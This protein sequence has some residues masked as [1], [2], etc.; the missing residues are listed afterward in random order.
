[1]NYHYSK[2][3][4][5]LWPDGEYTKAIK[6]SSRSIWATKCIS[7]ALLQQGMYY[8]TYEISL[9]PDVLFDS[10]TNSILPL[11]KDLINTYGT[12]IF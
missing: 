9:S 3:A 1:M 4:T 5:P 12:G 6:V 2:V 11:R 10:T 7:A 8:R